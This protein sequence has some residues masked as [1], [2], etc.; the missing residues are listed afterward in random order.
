MR[1]LRYIFM[2][3][4]LIPSLIRAADDNEAVAATAY[5]KD[6]LASCGTN[7]IRCVWFLRD[8]TKI[9]MLMTLNLQGG[10]VFTE[11]E[12]YNWA[13][14]SS[15]TRSLTHSQV[16]SLQDIIGQMPSSNKR[17]EFSGAVSVSLWRKGKVEIF[18][19]DRH[20][21]PPV[22]RRLYDIGGGYFYDGKDA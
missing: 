1:M 20:H 6:Y 9:G 14:Q 8:D 7:E 2:C 15:E 13:E 10:T 12:V 5:F 3:V 18:H 21:A 17:I 16:L 22:I 11:R 4:A 19:Y